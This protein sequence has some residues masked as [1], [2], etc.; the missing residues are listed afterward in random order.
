MDQNFQTTKFP[1]TASQQTW[2]G[3]ATWTDVNNIKADDAAVAFIGLAGSGAASLYGSDYGFSLPPN[4][5]VDGI[6]VNIDSPLQYGGWGVINL[7]LGID[8]TDFKDA[9]TVNGVF[10]GPTDLWGRDSIPASELS[11]INIELFANGTVDDGIS[12]NYISVTVYWHIEMPAIETDVPTRFAYKVYSRDGKYLGELPKVTT[13]LAF[14]EDINSAGT[15]IEIVCGKFADNEV[16]VSP[17][18][19]EAGET[20]TTE[21]DLP[22][23]VTSTDVAITTGDSPDDAVFKNSNRVK[24][25]MYNQYYPNG[26]LMFSGQINRVA[27]RYKTGD[28][29]IRVKLFSD[30]LDLN[31]YIARGYPFAYTTDVSQANS[32]TDMT[33][34]RSKTGGWTFC[35]QTWVVGAGVNNIGALTLRLVG[36]ATV[37]VSIYDGVNG[38][39]LGSATRAVS[40]GVYANVRFDFPQLIT[41]TPGSQYFFTVSVNSNQ[42]MRVKYNTSSSTY[43]NGSRYISN[44]GG[45]SGGGQFLLTTG[46]LHFITASG[47]P[48]TTTTYSSQDP[49]TGMARGILLD[50]N[51]RGG[52]ITERDF[53][54][55][56]VALTY[57][58]VV[59]VIN[60]AIRKILELA[61][62]GYYAYVDLGTSEIDI[63]KTS[64]LAD[65]TIVRGRHINELD[66]DLSIE[67]VKNDLLFSGGEVSPGV[68]LYKEY[69]DQ[70][71]NAYYGQ[72]LATQSDNRVTT[73][74]TAD[75]IG[76]TFIEEYSDEIQ[77]TT[78]TVLNSEIDITL[79]TPGKTVGF[80]NFGNF[81][82]NMVLQIV[83]REPNYS[84]GIC[85]L[86]LGR[87]P[88]RMSE[89]IEKINRDLML[90][91]TA[92]N[93]TSPS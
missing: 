85:V 58:F 3:G 32:N 93:P 77:E 2:T 43:A 13:K 19:T 50:Y 88:V 81:I 33:I 80:R 86:S 30:G 25:W 38:N 49:V 63:K 59:A 40:T 35:G 42:S 39:F 48:T 54:A 5:V 7:T 1:N 34:T 36:K 21:N 4:A 60:D 15:S 62:N 69:K 16:T 92:N 91:Q 17:L 64:E 75:A 87:L 28:A 90:Q 41:L 68:N 29:Y 74:P 27:L 67:Q 24:V 44:Y 89:K 78:L 76:N 72:R 12:I 20:I 45:G 70:Q 53:E 52:L 61:G 22:I 82:D 8:D 37:T 9:L 6:A 51:A 10:G 71:S 56:N 26:K 14:P 73:T 46:D 79:L 83:R 65:F 66:L 31:N 57:T 11:D 55:A 23:L 47:V 84:D 18:Q